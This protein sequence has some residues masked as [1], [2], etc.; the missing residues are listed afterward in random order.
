[1][2]VLLAILLCR[3]L[4]YDWSSLPTAGHCGQQRSV[5]ATIAVID[6]V[7]DLAILILPLSMIWNLQLPKSTRIALTAILCMGVL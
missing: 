2:T 5:Y 1:M 7:T 3:P 6:I 4:D